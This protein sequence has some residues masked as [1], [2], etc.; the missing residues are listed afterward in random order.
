MAPDDAERP[1]KRW[2]PKIVVVATIL[3]WRVALGGRVGSAK[4]NCVAEVLEEAW[5][6]AVREV[7]E[8]VT[9]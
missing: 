3:A 1:A 2:S 6:M 7:H 8:A 5:R 4:Q 9:L